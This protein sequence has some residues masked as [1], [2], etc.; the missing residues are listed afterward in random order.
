MISHVFFWLIWCLDYVACGRHDISILPFHFQIANCQI[1]ILL[2]SLQPEFFWLVRFL[3]S[4]NRRNGHAHHPSLCG[5]CLP[6]TVFWC[7]SLDQVFDPLIFCHFGLQQII[8]L[9]WTAFGGRWFV[10]MQKDVQTRHCAQTRKVL[11]QL[12]KHEKIQ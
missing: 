5:W 10:W 3:E 1:V 4:E 7:E 2:S 6:A 12:F 8:I 11:A 9:N